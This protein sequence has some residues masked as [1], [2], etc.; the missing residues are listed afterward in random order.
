MIPEGPGADVKVCADYVVIVM[1]NR[2]PTYRGWLLFFRVYD[3][4]TGWFPQVNQVLGK[5]GVLFGAI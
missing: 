5:L 1:R 3:R 4:R 2:I